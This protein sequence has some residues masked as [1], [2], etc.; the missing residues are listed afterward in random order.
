MGR[1]AALGLALLCL[2]ACDRKEGF[3][4]AAIKS[5]ADSAPARRGKAP[6][7][8]ECLVRAVVADMSLEEVSLWARTP[9]LFDEQEMEVLLVRQAMPCLKPQ[10]VEGCVYDGAS[11]EECGC[12]ASGI[13]EAF[14]ADQLLDLSER[15]RNGAAVSPEAARIRL[16]CASKF[17]A[18]RVR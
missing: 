8:C 12:V 10:L 16:D 13:L 2:C 17:R 7:D 18:G 14:P 4:K 5:C 1:L 3:T 15:M 9:D 11:E 6:L